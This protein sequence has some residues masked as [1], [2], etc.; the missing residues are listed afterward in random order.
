MA[1]EGKREYTPYWR[2]LK[3][4]GTLNDK[5]PGGVVAQAGLLE[6]EG[7]CIEMDKTGKPKK[8]IDFEKA[9]VDY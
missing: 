9:L 4:G 7:H 2:T 3:V 8:V 6:A 1:S 5:F